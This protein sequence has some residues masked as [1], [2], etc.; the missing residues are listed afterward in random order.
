M[1][2][3]GQQNDLSE[4]LMPGMLL[5]AHPAMRDPHF[6]RAVILLTAYDPDQGAMGVVFNQPMQQPLGSLLHPLAEST[7][8]EVPLYR[9]GPVEPEQLV[10]SAWRWDLERRAHFQ[11]YFGITA[12]RAQTLSSGQKP[13][14]LR[15]FLGYA[16]WGE[17]QLEEEIEEGAWVC[18]PIQPG[19]E[20]A[21]GDQLWKSLVCA[22]DPRYRIL[23][24]EPEDPTRN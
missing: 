7:L 19:L 3:M 4:G 12:E 16:G 15:A 6:A 2:R 18:Q 23:C 10:L 13:F 14:H 9:G 1:S 21:D 11:L 22:I 5:L 20:T 8:G 24:D 17:G